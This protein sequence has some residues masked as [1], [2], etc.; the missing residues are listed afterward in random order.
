MGNKQILFRPVVCDLIKTIL[1]FELIWVIKKIIVF[2]QS[3]D[4]SAHF[5]TNKKF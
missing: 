3:P 5:K 1:T 2:V 4:S